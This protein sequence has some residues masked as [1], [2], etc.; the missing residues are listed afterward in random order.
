MMYMDDA[1]E[2]P[3]RVMQASAEQIKIRSSYNLAA[4]RFS[5]KEIAAEIQKHTPDFTIS[6]A[7]DFR[8]KIADSWPASINDSEARKDW[9]WHHEFNLESMTEDMLEHL[10]EVLYNHFTS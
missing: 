10:R 8:Q 7:P 5:P 9:N 2:A 1:I 3:I 4:M 6:H